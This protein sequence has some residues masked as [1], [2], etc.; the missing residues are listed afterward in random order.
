MPLVIN[1]LGGGHTDT[2]TCTPTHKVKQFQ[3]T[4]HVQLKATRAWFKKSHFGLK[5]TLEL[6]QLF[7]L[8]LTVTWDNLEL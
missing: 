2:H 6:L 3:E 7:I 4:R 5:T 8:T 1:A